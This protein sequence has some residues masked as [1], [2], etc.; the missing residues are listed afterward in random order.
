MTDSHQCRQRQ[1]ASSAHPPG[2]SLFFPV[3]WLSP[4][5]GRGWHCLEKSHNTCPTCVIWLWEERRQRGCEPRTS[6]P[7]SSTLP[8]SR[9]QTLCSLH[10]Q[11]LLLP[12]STGLGGLAAAVGMVSVMPAASLDGWLLL[13]N[14]RPQTFP[15]PTSGCPQSSYTTVITRSCWRPYSVTRAGNLTRQPDQVNFRKDTVSY[16]SFSPFLK[17][18]NLMFRDSG[19]YQGRRPF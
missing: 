6:C 13:C 12:E 9:A 18:L 8:I 4:P 17:S 19:N 7:S 15:I 3:S 16:L 5:P 10:F 2:K 14:F 1:A 11:M